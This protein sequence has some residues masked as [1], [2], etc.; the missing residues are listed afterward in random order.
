LQRQHLHRLSWTPRFPL[1]REARHDRRL[2]NHEALKD[3]GGG[4]LTRGGHLPAVFIS[5]E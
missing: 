5:V 3:L 4:P 1:D 2:T